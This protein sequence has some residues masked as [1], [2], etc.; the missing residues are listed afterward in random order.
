[1]EINSKNTGGAIFVGTVHQDAKTNVTKSGLHVANFSICYGKEDGDTGA[2]KG[3]YI[4][5]IAWRDLADYAANLE[6]GDVVLAAGTLSRDEY[7]SN[8][9]GSDVY[10][11][12][13]QIIL[14]QPDAMPDVFDEEGD[15]DDE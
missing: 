5:C 14:V 3:K 4:N 7:R 8:K 6:A 13:C 1:M 11:L 10:Q 12:T 9:K 15:E 2:K